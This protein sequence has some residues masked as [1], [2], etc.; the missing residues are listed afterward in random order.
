MWINLENEDWVWDDLA[1]CLV[2]RFSFID[3]SELLYLIQNRLEEK[4]V[5]G[6]K[7]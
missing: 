1:K 5:K 3:L 6:K 2:D 7:E 4:R